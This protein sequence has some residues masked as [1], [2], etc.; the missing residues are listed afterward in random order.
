MEEHEH[1]MEEHEHGIDCP[2]CGEHISAKTEAELIKK[3]QKHALKVHD[4]ETNDTAS[5]LSKKK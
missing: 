4:M 5:M 2:I 3:F 1:G